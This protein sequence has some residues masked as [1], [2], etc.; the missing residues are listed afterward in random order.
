M[1]GDFRSAG[2]SSHP[3]LAVFSAV[4]VSG[5]PPVVGPEGIALLQNVPN[6]VRRMTT[7]GFALAR[8]QPVTLRVHDLSGRVV[9]TPF[10]RETL[11]AGPHDWS[12]DVSSLPEGVYFYSLTVA[13][14]TISK[15]MIVMR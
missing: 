7:I 15:R 3:N 13:N 12:L 1:G 2:G 9:R 4:G 14:R 6:P 5:V 11:A 8:S 10:D